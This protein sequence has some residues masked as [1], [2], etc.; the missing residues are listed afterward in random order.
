M[1]PTAD[2]TIFPAH[3]CLQRQLWGHELYVRSLDALWR[4]SGSPPGLDPA[5]WLR[6]A[7]EMVEAV[8][9]YVDRLDP[10]C[11]LLNEGARSAVWSWRWDLEPRGDWQAGDTLAIPPVGSLYA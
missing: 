8:S 5:S 6:R 3:A 11:R 7:G 2:R 10:E 1:I 4:A 9:W